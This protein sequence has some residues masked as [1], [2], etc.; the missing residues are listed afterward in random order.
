MR[1][2]ELPSPYGELDVLSLGLHLHKLWICLNPLESEKSVTSM[3][4]LSVL[5]LFSWRCRK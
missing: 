3:G 5:V 4:F 2:E 1:E